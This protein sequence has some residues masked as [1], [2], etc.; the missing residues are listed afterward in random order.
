MI[1]E[2][3]AD[4]HTTSQEGEETI[5]SYQDLVRV[6]HAHPDWLQQ[7]RQM[8]L[9]YDLIEL[10]RRFEEFTRREFAPL[11]ATIEE[12]GRRLEHVEGDVAV[13]KGDVNVLKADV[14]ELKQD[15]TVL[16]A[17]VNELKQDVT[18][19]KADVSELK[20]DVTVL[21]ADVSELKQDVTVLKQDV[22]VLKQDVTVLKADVS[23][24]KQ[25]VTVLKQDVTV[26][27]Q[28]VAVL[29]Q[30]VAVL[31]QDVA[32]LKQDVAQLKRDVAILQ[33]RV[34]RMANELAELKG[35]DF[36]RSLRE[37]APA[38]FARVLRRC[39]VVHHEQLAER[40]EDA[41]EARKIDEAAFEDAL[42][43]DL[44]VSGQMKEDRRPV[45]LAIEASLTV[46]RG[47]VE[48]AARR[49]NII[50]AATGCEVIGVAFSKE[51]LTDGA[52]SLA[53]E[54]GVLLF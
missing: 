23:E 43:I 10:P 44:V 41:L 36:E 7:F 24:L 28:D 6:F 1:A 14:N 30:D 21:K 8:V 33:A 50:A 19:L 20:Q 52:R 3:S 45:M 46:D 12:Q 53:A 35:N 29:K 34:D 18:V 39:R 17:D 37:K 2:A 42:T 31:K 54:C 9:T 26:L 16:K 48:R 38:R 27:K 47:D 5:A 49:A 4:S 25:D 32:V 13:L 40:L 22:A 11:K 15:V 51:T